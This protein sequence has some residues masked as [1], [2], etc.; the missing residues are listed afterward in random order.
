[1]TPQE[2][3][4]NGRLREAIT[5][6]GEELRKSPLDVK[7]RTFLFELLCFA[8]EYGRAEKQLTVLADS[9]QDAA[10]RAMLRPP[11]AETCSRMKSIQR[12]ATSG[13]HSL[14][15]T[16]NSPMAKGVDVCALMV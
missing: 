8:G 11:T 9:R 14:R 3:Y 1:M 4:R 15:F 13:S 10:F 7:R 16:N 2:L 12:F 5:A 6:L